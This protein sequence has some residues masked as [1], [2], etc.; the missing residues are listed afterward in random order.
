MYWG[1]CVFDF[2]CQ[3]WY[4]TIRLCSETPKQTKVSPAKLRKGINIASGNTMVKAF[5]LVLLLFR[6]WK[7]R[8]LVHGTLD[9]GT[10]CIMQWLKAADR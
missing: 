8:S 7:Q 3:N 10:T 1:F 5:H 4:R 6:Q 2:L 9:G